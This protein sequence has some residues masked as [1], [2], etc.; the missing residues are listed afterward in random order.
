MFNNIIDVLHRFVKQAKIFRKVLDSRAS[1]KYYIY[2]DDIMTVTELARI[3]GFSVSTVSKALSDSE[4]ISLET[5]KEILRAARETGYYDKAIR[6]KKRIGMPKTVGIIAG[7]MRDARVL[8][9]LCR[10]LDKRNISSVISLS[11]DSESLFEYLG[12]DCLL[13]FDGTAR[14]SSLPSLVFD[15][16]IYKTADTLA[17]DLSV[18]SEAATEDENFSQRSKKE[19]IWLF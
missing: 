4:E 2:G 11:D 1:L 17:E 16:D 6:R 18:V 7:D 5:K 3:T 9:N 13:F 8:R 15:G 10:E 12:I 19:D 14:S